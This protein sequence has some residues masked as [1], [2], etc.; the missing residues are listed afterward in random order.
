MI[1]GRQCGPR[2]KGF[3][4]TFGRGFRKKESAW[5][6]MSKTRFTRV[7]DK[8]ARGGESPLS[9]EHFHFE[10]VCETILPMDIQTSPQACRPAG[11]TKSFFLRKCCDPHHTQPCLPLARSPEQINFSKVI[12]S[13]RTW[14]R[15]RPGTSGSLPGRP[16]ARR[17]PGSGPRPGRWCRARRAWI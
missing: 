3:P 8:R 5:S 6:E 10:N 14:Y 12:C 4:P 15:R 2:R 11:W 7:F 1:L 13:S 9:L 17:S 16:G